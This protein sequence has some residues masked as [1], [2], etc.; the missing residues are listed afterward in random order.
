[1]PHVRVFGRGKKDHFSALEEPE[2]AVVAEAA[3]A[4]EAAGA[5]VVDAESAAGLP[6]ALPEAGFGA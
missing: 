2:E 5:A 6:D 1:V 3:G 4:L